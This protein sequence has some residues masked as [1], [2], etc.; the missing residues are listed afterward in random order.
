MSITIGHKIAAFKQ[1]VRSWMFGKI[2]AG[3][4]SGSGS[5]IFLKIGSPTPNLFI[6][7]TNLLKQ[8]TQKKTIIV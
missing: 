2:A 4:I 1:T 5:H 3:L 8:L 6:S 7:P